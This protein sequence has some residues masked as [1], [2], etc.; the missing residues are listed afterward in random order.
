MLNKRGIHILLSCR[1]FLS[2]YS[3]NFLILFIYFFDSQRECVIFAAEIQG[4]FLLGLLVFLVYCRIWGSQWPSDF[5]SSN[6]SQVVELPLNWIIHL[7]WWNVKW[8]FQKANS[9]PPSRVCLWNLLEAFP[10]FQQDGCHFLL[11]D[12]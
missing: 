11:W 4:L 2:H 5:P 7:W 3:V 9:Q 12:P 8:A 6:C 1:D 10:S